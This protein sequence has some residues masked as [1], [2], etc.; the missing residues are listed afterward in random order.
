MDF[1]FFIMTQFSTTKSKSTLFPGS[2]FKFSP[3][4]L[5]SFLK[6]KISTTNQIVYMDSQQTQGISLSFPVVHVSFRNM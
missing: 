3:K 6:D 4:P 1:R 5:H 2:K